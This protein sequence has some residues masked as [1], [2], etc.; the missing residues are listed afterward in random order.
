MIDIVELVNIFI[1]PFPL[2][3]QPKNKSPRQIS[4]QPLAIHVT[5]LGGKGKL[6]DFK[7]SPCLLECT[8]KQ[9]YYIQE[10]KCVT[11]YICVKSRNLSSVVVVLC[12]VGPTLS[13]LVAGNALVM[14]E[15]LSFRIKKYM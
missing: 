11:S 3:R 7:K 12:H 2:N 6:L 1:L 4:N 13:S 14:Y 15:E 9:K 10:G 8:Y 5:R